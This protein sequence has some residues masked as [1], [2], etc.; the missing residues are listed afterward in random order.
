MKEERFHAS[1]KTLVDPGYLKVAG[2]PSSSKEGEKEANK[3]FIDWLEKRKERDTLYVKELVIKEGETT[4]PKQG[5]N[6]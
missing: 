5:Y 6:R 1:F 2:I 4:P 3:N